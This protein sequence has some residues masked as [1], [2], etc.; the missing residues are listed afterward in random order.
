MTT[1]INCHETRPHA[2][3]YYDGSYCTGALGVECPTGGAMYPDTF[4]LDLTHRITTAPLCSC[5]TCVVAR[6]IRG[7]RRERA[8]P[9]NGS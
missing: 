8:D 9:S 3:H 1:K 2:A 6:W 7:N 4:E 5:V